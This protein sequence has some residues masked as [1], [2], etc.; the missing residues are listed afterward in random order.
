MMANANAEILDCNGNTA[1]HLACYGGKL[2]CLRILASYVL[3]P[4]IFDTI[5]YDGMYLIYIKSINIILNLIIV[6]E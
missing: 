6:S 2:D 4:K 1:V 5:N 3:L